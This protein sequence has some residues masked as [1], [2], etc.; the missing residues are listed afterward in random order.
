MPPV[1]RRLAASIAML[2]SAAAVTWLAVPGKA[3]PA[4]T[5]TATAGVNPARVLVVTATPGVAN[6]LS[7][8][9]SLASSGKVV[10]RDSAGRVAA[11]APC[12][13]GYAPEQN[14]AVCPLA[15]VGRVRVD[16]GDGNDIAAISSARV[17]TRSGARTWGADL[18]GGPGNDILSGSWGADRLIAGDGDDTL[19]GGPGNDGLDAGPGNDRARGGDG[20]DRLYGR[21]GN[22]YLDAGPGDDRPVLGEGGNDRIFGGDGNDGLDGGDGNDNFAGGAGNDSI[23]GQ[24]GEDLFDGGPGADDLNGGPDGDTVTYGTRTATVVVDIQPDPLDSGD[25]DIDAAYSTVTGRIRYDKILATERVIGG[26][27]AD[28]VYARAV[29]GA[30]IW[31]G[32]GDDIIE[33]EDGTT[34]FADCGPGIHDSLGADDI[35]P[36]PVDQW[37]NCEDVSHVIPN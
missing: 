9:F 8:S 19:T 18:Y 31:S 15:A 23:Y 12:R 30:K 1:K 26:S 3:L 28:I 33:L 17:V 13:Q 21:D 36:G 29:D 16:A 5:T 11:S 14:A 25:W 2:A 35:G 24:A 4:G 34:D 32:D 10:V 27:A 37:V 22:D 20:N 6:R 7:V